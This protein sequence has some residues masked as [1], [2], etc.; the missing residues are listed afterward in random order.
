MTVAANFTAL[1]LAIAA[2][3]VGVVNATLN[4]ET[5]L[6]ALANN[7]APASAVVVDNLNPSIVSGSG[8]NPIR[9]DTQRKRD[10]SDDSLHGQFRRLRG[11][12]IPHG[13]SLNNKVGLEFISTPGL[14]LAGRQIGLDVAPGFGV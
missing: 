2:L 8:T 1:P 3:N 6:Q 5:M 9:L 4:Y 7:G 12:G 14:V 10:Q 11:I 13:G